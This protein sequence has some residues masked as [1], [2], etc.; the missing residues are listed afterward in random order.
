[1]IISILTALG[2]ALGV[3]IEALLGGSSTSTPTSETTT[4][5]DRKGGA[6]SG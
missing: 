6:R 3:L 4:T 1:M 2:M 5:S